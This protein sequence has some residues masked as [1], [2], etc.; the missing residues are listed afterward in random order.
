MFIV[1]G[2]RSPGA[3]SRGSYRRASSATASAPTGG[4]TS[5]GPNAA[6][7]A[8]LPA[9]PGQHLLPHVCESPDGLR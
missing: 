1:K 6:F 2:L 5:C 7:A 9:H 4:S 8:V 3:E